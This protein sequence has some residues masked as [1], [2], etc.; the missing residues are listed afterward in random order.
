MIKR[1]L[2]QAQLDAARAN[3]ALSKGPVTPEG[4]AVSSRNSLTHGMLA[5]SVLLPG[6]SEEEFERL[7]AALMEEWRPET[8]D[9]LAMVRTMIV[10]KWR[11]MR[12]WTLLAAG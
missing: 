9:E 6:E 12:T 4:K 2:S 8:A 11:Q 7:H 1:P 10:A 3:G 5:N